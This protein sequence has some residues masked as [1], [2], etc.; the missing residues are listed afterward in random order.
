[1]LDAKTGEVKAEVGGY[2]FSMAKFNHATQGMRQT[3]S[4]FKPFIYSAAIEA[5]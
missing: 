4:A 1:M 5:V 3:G 2:D